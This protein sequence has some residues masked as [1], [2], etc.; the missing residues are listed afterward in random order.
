MDRRSRARGA[1]IEAEEVAKA[2]RLEAGERG[3][4]D[5]GIESAARDLAAGGGGLD[6]CL[7]GGDVRAARDQVGGDARRQRQGGVEAQRRRADRGG[8]IGAAAGERRQRVDRARAGA[9]RL[10]QRDARLRQQRLRGGRLQIARQPVAD[11]HVDQLYRP[12]ARRDRAAGE[13]RLRFGAREVDVG[14]HHRPRDREAGG[15]DIERGGTGGGARALDRGLLAAE[16]VEVPIEVRLR[17]A[18]EAHRSGIGR[19]DGVAARQA[20]NLCRSVERHVGAALRIARRQH[21][22]RLRDTGERGVEIGIALRRVGDEAVELR[23]AERGPPIVRDG[24][25]RFGGKPQRRGRDRCDRRR[26]VRH[27]ARA[28]QQSEQQGGF[29]L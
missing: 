29:R 7:R 27:R 14:L 28:R 20:R 22:L 19:R 1:G 13:R 16:Q 9:V 3:E 21:R 15:R 12:F 4:V 10:R 25:R 18:E 2:D 17:T 26:A 11:A 24:G 6:P 5:V 8:I 23:I